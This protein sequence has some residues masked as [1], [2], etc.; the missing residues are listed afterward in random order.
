[1]LALLNILLLLMKRPLMELSLTWAAAFI[2]VPLYDFFM[3]FM[4]MDGC[5]HSVGGDGS[6]ASSSKRPR[7]D[8]NVGPEQNGL[9]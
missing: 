4:D 2:V 9:I 5:S 6:G 3:S 7:L 1:M 8:L